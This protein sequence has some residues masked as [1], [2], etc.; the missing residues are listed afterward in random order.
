MLGKSYKSIKHMEASNFHQ[1]PG[2]IGWIT[3]PILYLP[4]GDGSTKSPYTEDRS[5]FY[6]ERPIGYHVED[7]RWL[8]NGGKDDGSSAWR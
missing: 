5:C 7:D 4:S 6:D 1:R 2:R 3:S 8:L